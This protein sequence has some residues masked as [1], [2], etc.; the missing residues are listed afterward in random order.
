ML[1]E[2]LNLAKLERLAV[3][4]EVEEKQAERPGKRTASNVVG[5]LWRCLL[6]ARTT[7]FTTIRMGVIKS[8][9]HDLG[10]LSN[11]GAHLHF[12]SALRVCLLAAQAA[13]ALLPGIPY[14]EKTVH[15][16]VTENFWKRTF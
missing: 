4:F 16:P 11:G 9:K 6:C 12:R 13:N 14:S 2:S 3:S 8:S 5:V 15:L 1:D 7:P 10:F